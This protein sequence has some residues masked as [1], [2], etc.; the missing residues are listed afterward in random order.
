M[1]SGVRA[2]F[3]KHTGAEWLVPAALC[4]VMLMQMLLSVRQMSQHADEAIHL[5]AGYRVLKCG[6][7]AY[8]R[9]HPPLAKMIAAA[10]LL[11]SNIPMDCSQREVGADE[12][13]QATRWFYSQEDW[14]PLLMKARIASSLSAVV[15]CLG[16]WVVAR[17]MFGLVV[18]AVSTAVLAFEP[19]I[20]GHGA[21]LLNN[22]LLAAMF[23]LTVFCFYRW[24]RERSE[25]LLVGT[26]FSLGLALLTKHSA[27]LLIPI[28]LVLAVAD[29]WMETG[30]KGKVAGRAWRNAGALVLIGVIAA[31]SIWG[32]YGVRYSQA[33]RRATDSLSVEQLASITSPDVQVLK[34]MRLAHILPQ[35]YLD[36]VIE[37][38]TMI[39]SAADVVD[40]L[41]KPYRMPPWFFFPLV[42][43]IKFTVGFLAMLARI[44]HQ[45]RF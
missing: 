3:A 32:C 24:T 21:L 20:L 10:P 14:W 4:A 26:G 27:V 35:P 2:F 37:V 36:G 15:L 29:A 43:I 22:V 12:E 1:F 41:G 38:R 30:D 8:G 19:N 5:Y 40:V 31:V 39:T 6:D 42:V 9:E 17:R 33:R 44:S 23:L 25:P 28:L 34:A 18:A 16:V 7:Y 45:S 11:W 13:E